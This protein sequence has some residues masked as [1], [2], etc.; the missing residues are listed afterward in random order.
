MGRM[1]AVLFPL[2]LFVRS[3]VSFVR[4]RIAF[5]SFHLLAR[6]VHLFRFVHVSFLNFF[7]QLHHLAVNMETGQANILTA[8]LK[9]NFAC[10]STKKQSKPWR[11]LA[12]RI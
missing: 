10:N 8:P 1:A 11:S 7:R 4:V 9:L 6:F 5:R 12:L 3:L 2:V